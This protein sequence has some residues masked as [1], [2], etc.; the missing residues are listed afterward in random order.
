MS[1]KFI[2]SIV[3][4]FMALISIFT[5]SSMNG[6]TVKA[7]SKT[8]SNK[9]LVVYYSNSGTTEA[10]AK[11][12]QKQTGGDLVKLK[13]SPNYPSDYNKLT[14][15]AKRQ[16][17]KNIHPKI[18][19]KIKMN[20]YKTV[21]LGFPTWYQRPPMFINTFFNKYNLKNKTVVPFTT[22]M[23]SPM[24]VNRPYLKKMARGKKINLQS[25]FRA[26]SAKKTTKYLKNNNL[27]K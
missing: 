16:I 17:D 4:S 1:K 18:L 6:S 15:V 12:I 8:S 23:S 21:L 27:M 2:Y 24:K 5:F 9:V 3:L 25:G 22:S 14:K 26:N 11:R 19:N 20:K 10:A 7:A 13:L